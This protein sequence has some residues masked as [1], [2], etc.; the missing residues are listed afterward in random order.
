VQQG[1]TATSPA[2]SDKSSI[3][4]SSIL[5]QPR[6]AS[7]RRPKSLLGAG[8]YGADYDEFFEVD[9]EEETTIENWRGKMDSMTNFM[10][11]MARRKRRLR[12]GEVRE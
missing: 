6:M 12:I 3:S 7:F 11:S 8:G 5:S 1:S 2:T 9:L 10:R 4:K